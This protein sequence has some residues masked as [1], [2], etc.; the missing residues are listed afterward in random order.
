MSSEQ[1]SKRTNGYLFLYL[2][3][4]FMH[5]FK[6][7]NRTHKA[8]AALWDPLPYSSPSTP[9]CSGAPFGRGTF[10]GGQVRSLGDFGVPSF[11]RCSTEPLHSGSVKYR[12]CCSAIALTIALP[13]PGRG[14]LKK[15]KNCGISG[16][17]SS[18]INLS[19]FTK[20]FRGGGQLKWVCSLFFSIP[21]LETGLRVTH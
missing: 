11:R 20:H 14:R 15:K 13:G 19:P 7:K 3:L 8:V 18:R 17:S 6:R 10:P 2:Y 12:W 5:C 16:S 9:D 21:C 1:I 4:T